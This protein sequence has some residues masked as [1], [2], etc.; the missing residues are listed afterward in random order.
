MRRKRKKDDVTISMTQYK[1]FLRQERELK[2]Y[3]IDGFLVAEM[4]TGYS[5][6]DFITAP[7]THLI[8]EP[9]KLNSKKEKVCMACTV[10]VKGITT[11]AYVLKLKDDGKAQ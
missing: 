4:I 7:P 8:L 5:G 9:D 1:V 11:R 2:K 3:K 10:Q 6:V